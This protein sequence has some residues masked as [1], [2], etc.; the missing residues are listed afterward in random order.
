M[1]KTVLNI[2][3]GILVAALVL[4]AWNSYSV[5]R[6]KN[7]FDSL[8]AQYLEGSIPGEVEVYSVH[9]HGALELND[10]GFGDVTIGIGS[11]EA[12]RNLTGKKA[13]YFASLTL[14]TYN[15][16]EITGKE[17]VD[18]Y[19]GDTTEFGGYRIT[20]KDLYFL[21]TGF[22]KSIDVVFLEIRP[23]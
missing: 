17:N 13:H 14:Y 8:N 7:R 12:D 16:S 1:R 9:E 22:L 20:I 18:L 11:I 6:S 21:K 19:I 10:R 3:I 2:I 15:S 23:D 4:V 5:R